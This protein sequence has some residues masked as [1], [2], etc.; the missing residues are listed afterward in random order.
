MATYA[1]LHTQRAGSTK[2]I[3]SLLPAHLATD[4]DKAKDGEGEGDPGVKLRASRSK[5]SKKA[6]QDEVEK[7]ERKA[8][9]ASLEAH[10]ANLVK[11]MT[12]ACKPRNPVPFKKKSNLVLQGGYLLLHSSWNW[13]GILSNSRSREFQ[14]IAGAAVLEYNIIAEYRDALIESVPAAAF[15]RSCIAKHL[16]P[17]LKINSLPMRGNDVSRGDHAVEFT[18]ADQIPTPAIKD[19]EEFDVPECFT[20]WIGYQD[21]QEDQ[22]AVQKMIHMVEKNPLAWKDP[23]NKD[24]AKSPAVNEAVQKALVLL[25]KVCI[26]IS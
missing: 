2:E 4:D 24:K 26:M 11:A 6:S 9:K 16:N 19:P 18:F 10:C 5:S 12:A 15:L 17:Y 3:S 20:A 8:H 21:M 1:S 23:F 13:T 25:V 14:H 22:Q 7:K